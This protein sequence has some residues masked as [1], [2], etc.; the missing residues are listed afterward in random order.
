MQ[1]NQALAS[2]N[3]MRVSPYKLNDIAKIIRQKKVGE[4]IVLLKGAKKRS[5][6]DV[7]KTLLSAIA[8]A[9]NNF[10]LDVD[11]LVVTEA[12][13]GRAIVLRRMD[14][15][16]RSRMGRITKPFSN[17]RVVVTAMNSGL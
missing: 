1:N 4:A 17:L 2:F 9:K 12:T 8:N 16:G 11:Q 10:D 5:A 6:H 14:I 15:K 3:M 7:L 13:V